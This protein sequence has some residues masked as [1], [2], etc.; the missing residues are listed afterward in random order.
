MLKNLKENVKVQQYPEAYGQ[1]NDKSDI[2]LLVQ[3]DE[4]YNKK[5]TIPNKS[6]QNSG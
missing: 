5:E 3:K 2:H 1:D 6:V 4:I